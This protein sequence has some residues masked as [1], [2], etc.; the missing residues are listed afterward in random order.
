MWQHKGLFFTN[1]VN[2]NILWQN[3]RGSCPIVLVLLLITFFK[4][5]FCPFAGSRF[6]FQNTIILYLKIKKNRQCGGK[7]NSF[8]RFT[9]PRFFYTEIYFMPQKAF[10]SWIEIVHIEIHDWF[11][12]KYKSISIISIFQYA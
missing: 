7:M 6:E 2:L 5:Q 1:W 9:Q 12:T 10:I 11:C 3:V 4:Y 8:P